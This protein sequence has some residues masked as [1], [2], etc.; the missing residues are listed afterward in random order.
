MLTGPN[1]LQN[2]FERRLPRHK[3]PSL[4][5][6]YSDFQNDSQHSQIPHDTSAFPQYKYTSDKSKVE[7]PYFSLLTQDFLLYNRKNI[8]SAFLHPRIKEGYFRPKELPCFVTYTNEKTHKIIESNFYRAPLFTGQIQSIGPRYCPSIE[9]KINRFRDKERHQLF[10]EPQTY[11]KGEYYINGLST[12]L[13][14]EVQEQVIQS[15]EGL[16]K[17]VITRYGY[18]I[19]YDYSQPTNLFHTLESKIVK[20]LYLAGQINGTTGYEEAAAQGIMAGLNAALSILHTQGKSTRDSLVFDRSQAYI[21]VMIDDLVKKGTNEP[22]RVFTSRAEYRLLLREDNACFRMLPYSSELELL[23]KE[24]I[25]QLEKDKQNIESNIH[26]IHE[27][28]TPSKANLE[29]LSIIGEEKIV[30]KC[31]FGLILGRDSM[32]ASKMRSLD[33]RFSNLSTRALKQ[34]QIYAKY[35]SYIDKQEHQIQRSKENLQ[36]KIPHDFIYKGISGLSLEV[37]EKLSL[38]KPKTL[39]EAQRISGITPASLEVLQLHIAL[40]HKKRKI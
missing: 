9:D 32:N 13:P 16:E 19:E 37:I 17:A 31:H 40:Y 26:I 38:I 22:Y 7:A 25:L 28:F 14:Y 35:Q 36:L 29:K 5:K 12:S 2:I 21:G 34:I 1:A 11:S 23:N 27:D 20:N 4:N 39:Q 15:I 6:H 24:I 10:L 8:I 30:N 33:S 3:P 18:A